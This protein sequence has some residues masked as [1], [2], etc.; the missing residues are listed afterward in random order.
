MVRLNVNGETASLKKRKREQKDEADAKQKRVRSRPKSKHR[1][2]NESKSL[3]GLFPIQNGDGDIE[4]L[5]SSL[6]EASLA[7]QP[8][9]VSNPMGGRML[10][11]DPIF[12][13]DEKHLI[14]TYNTS[15]QVYSTDDSLLVRRI[16]IPV[17][18]PRPENEGEPVPAHIVS[19]VPSKVSPEHIWVACSDGRI[20]HINWVLGTGMDRPYLLMTKNVLDMTV[21][22][23]ELGS[24]AEDVLLV[25]QTSTKLLAQI[26]AYTTKALASNSGK[27]I[28]T[29][30][31][32]PQLLRSAVGA[33][34]VIVAA[35]DVV[36]IGLLKTKRKSANTLEALEYR[37]TAFNVPD[38][39]TCLDIRPTL[40][41]TRSGDELQALDLAVGC[42]RGAI[43][44][45][46]DV[47][48]KLPTT[49]SS[50]HKGSPIQ[51]QKYHWHR[52]AVHSV[53][54]SEDGNYLI[55]GGY[56]TV[57]VLFQLDTRK[58][59]YLPH[60]AAPIENI[61]VSPSGSSYAVHL[62]DNSTMVLSTAELKPTAYIT[63]IQSLVL[64]DHPPKES[65]VRRV[66]K[67]ADDISMPLVSAINPSNPSHIYL[68]VGNGQQAT[69][70]GAEPSMPLLQSF[71]I[72]SFQGLA[73]HALARTN[74]TD[75]NITS[76]GAPIV[77]PRV[78]KLAFSHDGQW[79]ASVDEW[80][81]P[82]R[83]VDVFVSGSKAPG[84]VAREKREIFLKFWHFDTNSKSVELVTRINEAHHTTQP[85]PIFDLASDPSSPRFAT[86]GNDGIV[87][88][89]TSK[90]RKRDGLAATGPEGQQLRSWSCSRVV[91]LPT[92]V[93]QDDVLDSAP[94]RSGALAFSED[95]SVLFAAFGTAAEAVVV[96]IDTETG[97]VR[98]VVS[99][100]FRGQVRSIKVLAC[101]LVM[102]SDDLTVYD[103]VADELR[104]SFTLKDTSEVTNRLTQLAVNYQS[105]CFA[106]VAP[107]PDSYRTKIGKGTKSELVILSTES[108]EPLF[109]KSFSQA[110][111][112]VIPAI[113]SSGF[114]VIDAAAQIWSVT[115]GAEQGQL[116][117]PL[118]DLGMDKEV[119]DAPVDVAVEEGEQSDEEMVD[120]DGDAEMEDYDIHQAV[121]AP[122]HLADIFNTAPAFAMPP[123]EDLF[124]QVAGLFSAKPTKA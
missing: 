47:L 88:F 50:S 54:W 122:Q 120:A 42:A 56:E 16:A 43:Y 61:A 108:S 68:C 69:L 46:K 45:Y 75:T 82:E 33:K 91:A 124:Y 57:L 63:G 15:I 99:G 85:E 90:L 97:A 115:Q 66:W 84:D 70:G 72:N 23:V 100:M 110:I 27:V 94:T 114:V 64:N 8:W 32:S 62:D 30:D 44:A 37:F 17:A 92:F 39:I 71:D 28:H 4:L 60:L 51:P 52:R 78:T 107:I 36:H 117:Q 116:L 113:T 118:A 58:Q 31:E 2:R 26:V 18:K 119:I 6:I 111:T 67:A 106:L 3:E 80:Q 12:S 123:I 104:Y 9:K 103:I 59:N 112:G 95:G 11:I 121:V 38:I 65:L 25:L 79:L 35:N 102:L 48:S 73:Q 40:Q 53:K 81:P 93:Q 24:L 49:A 20:W 5:D 13:S 109:T 105:R 96:A 14:L 1:T 86:L 101:C 21:E 22:S 83:D 76:Q 77:D 7:P 29:C 89:W 34:A 98:D 41:T 19:S 74:P 55:S 87:R 10:D